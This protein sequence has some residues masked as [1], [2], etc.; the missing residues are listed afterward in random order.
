MHFKQ[1][2]VDPDG[3]FGAFDANFTANQWACCGTSQKINEVAITPLDGV[4]LTVTFVPPNTA[5]WNGV[6]TGDVAPAVCG[7]LSERTALRGRNYRGRSFLGP[8]TEGSGTGGMMTGSIA[9]AIA[10]AWTSVQTAL[11]DDAVTHV[12]ASY[13]KSAAYPIL[14]YLVRNAFGTLRPRQS[15]LAT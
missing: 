3:L 12:V 7:V 10:N 5:K 4:G 1:N 14:E 2:S 8:A 13:A 6:Q 11:I 9:T 15:R